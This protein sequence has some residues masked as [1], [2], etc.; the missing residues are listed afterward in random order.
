LGSARNS[1]LARFA[2]SFRRIS[3]VK[4]RVARACDGRAAILGFSR[5]IA[6]ASSVQLRPIATR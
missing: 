5:A 6:M 2:K 4:H 1:I 3:R